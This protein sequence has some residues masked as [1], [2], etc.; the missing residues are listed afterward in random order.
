MQAIEWCHFRC[1]WVTR[2]PN[3]KRR[4]G[5]SASAGLSCLYKL[6]SPQR[7]R[8]ITRYALYKFT[9]LLSAPQT[10]WRPRSTWTRRVSLP[11]SPSR[12]WTM[13]IP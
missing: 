13:E 5:L 4:A 6:L 8:G 9:T 7:I 2:D 1:R 12:A 10:V 11:R 3:F